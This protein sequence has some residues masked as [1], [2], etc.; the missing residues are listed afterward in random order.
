MV[1]YKRCRSRTITARRGYGAENR[2]KVVSS[3]LG[4]A[5]R[6]R[7]T[8]LCQPSSKWVTFSNQGKIRLRKGRDGLRLAFVVPMI[9]WDSNPTAPTAIR[10]WETFTLTFRWGLFGVCFFSLA[11]GIFGSF[12]LSPLGEA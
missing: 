3:R 12:Y 5:I 10:L 11:Y 1:G 6:L 4:F 9:Q 8:F 7:K 2:Q